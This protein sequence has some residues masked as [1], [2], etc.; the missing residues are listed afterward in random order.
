M[1]AWRA[2]QARE[3]VRMDRTIAFGAFEGLSAETG[4]PGYSDLGNAGGAGGQAASIGSRHIDLTDGG[5][6]APRDQAKGPPLSRSGREAR[7]SVAPPSARHGA[8]LVLPAVPRGVPLSRQLVREICTLL[9]LDDVA[10]VA[11]LLASEV[12]TNAVLHARSDCLQVVVEVTSDELVVSVA[13]SDSCRPTMRQPSPDATRGRGL[14]LLDSLAKQWGV[15]EWPDGKAVWF[16]LSAGAPVGGGHEGHGPHEG[17]DHQGG[18][19][20]AGSGGQAVQSD[21]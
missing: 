3:R 16:T 21:E 17:H 7:V 8:Q 13:D 11:E 2:A 10:D 18:P 5:S 14:Y 9:A 19:G 15:I 6:S 1:R 12:V 20:D 4:S